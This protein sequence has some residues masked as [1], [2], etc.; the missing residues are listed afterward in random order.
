MGL[1]SAA[2]AACAGGTPLNNGRWYANDGSWF[3]DRIFVIG[4]QSTINGS[5]FSL[6][7]WPELDRIQSHI[8]VEAYPPPDPGVEPS[9]TIAYLTPESPLNARWYVIRWVSSGTPPTAYVHG[10]P[11][12]DGSVVWRFYGTEPPGAPPPVPAALCD[13]VACE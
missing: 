5:E 13:G 9:G 2:W 1:F 8:R 10:I 3:E 4:E 11:L 6:A 12:S 7:T